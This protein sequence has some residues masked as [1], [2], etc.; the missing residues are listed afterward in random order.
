MRYLLAGALALGLGLVVPGREAAACGGC[1]I[2]PPQ[3][4]DQASVV[5][6]HRMALSISPS[7]TILWDQIRYAG[8]PEEFVWVL[9]IKPGARIE[10]ATDA[11]IDVLDA[12]TSAIVY[13]PD[14]ECE[15]GGSFF[16]G[17]SVAA[18]RAHMGCG[19]DDVGM[20]DGGGPVDPAVTVVS[21]ASAGPYETVILKSEVPGALIGWLDDHGFEVPTDIHPL[22]DAYVGEGFDFVALRLL[23][24][25]GVQ[26]M[27]PV[28]VV[29][30]GAVTSLPLR[31]VA[32]GT[33]PFTDITLFVV[34]EGRF[35]AQGLTEA[36]LSVGELVWDFGTQSSNYASLRDRALATN[37]GHAL[38]VPFAARGA[39]F[40]ELE[41]LVTDQP[42]RFLTT[43]G[44]TFGTLARTYV[45]QAFINGETSSTACADWFVGL[46]GDTRKVVEPCTADGACAEVDASTSIDART[47]ACDPPLG[48][49]RPLDDLAQ[50]LVG[51][52]PADVWVTRLEARLPRSALAQ[53]LVLVPSASQKE[54]KSAVQA[55][56]ARGAPCELVITPPARRDGPARPSPRLGVAL[57]VGA[58]L[59]ATLLRRAARRRRADRAEVAA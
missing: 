21:H 30:P 5:S 23:P 16:G 40:T 19:G 42:M 37:G 52:H 7:Q 49:D 32:A 29:M 24:Q 34:G 57:M 3:T 2:P 54:K 41:N 27:V 56:Q 46:G 1:F 39:L 10:V 43:E 53:D 22:I 6:A 28:R 17:C 50:A 8:A 13:A 36:P 9:P 58:V 14:M 4:P 44:T 33:G 55:L 45:E 38:F 47:L 26:Q 31:M 20:E 35:T 48:S 59:A 12:A 11:W 15:S 51:M 18:S 25:V